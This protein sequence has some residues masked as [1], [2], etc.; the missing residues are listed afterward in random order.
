MTLVL[1]AEARGG[2][3]EK[4]KVSAKALILPGGLP[5]IGDISPDCPPDVLV[6]KF[7]CD[8]H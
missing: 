3:A 2:L 4:A 1:T 6:K 5:L 7:I 8:K